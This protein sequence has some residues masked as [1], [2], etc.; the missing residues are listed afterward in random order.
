M[1][2]SSMAQELS[3]KI[4]YHDLIRKIKVAHQPIPF[5]SELSSSIRARFMI[6]DQHLVGLRYTDPEGDLI[7]V[8]S[9]VELDEL[10]GEIEASAS[11]TQKDGVHC[12][13]VVVD[14]VILKLASAPAPL[15]LRDFH[16]TGS[17]SPPF[18]QDNLNTRSSGRHSILS[19]KSPVNVP[20]S[21]DVALKFHAAPDPP[22]EVL[23][24]D[25][26]LPAPKTFSPFGLQ[27][28]PPM[29]SVVAQALAPQLQH[30][31]GGCVQQVSD[32]ASQLNNTCRL[33]A[34]CLQK[35]S[36]EPSHQSNPH[37][38]A[39]VKTPQHISSPIHTTP[40]VDQSVN[41]VISPN[42]AFDHDAPHR[43]PPPAHLVDLTEPQ[44]PEAIRPQFMMPPA[45]SGPSSQFGARLRPQ[46][47]FNDHLFTPAAAPVPELGA[48]KTLLPNNHD[49]F[50]SPCLSPAPS[51]VP[52]GLGRTACS[53]FQSSYHSPP[54]S[55]GTGN[56]YGWASSPIAYKAVKETA[57]KPT[58]G[59]SKSCRSQLKG[60]WCIWPP[61]GYGSI[62]DPHPLY[63][64]ASRA[65]PITP[66]I[67]GSEKAPS[68]VESEGFPAS[69]PTSGKEPC[70]AKYSWWNDTPDKNELPDKLN[71]HELK[72]D[73]RGF[74]GSRRQHR[75]RNHCHQRK[76]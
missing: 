60:D 56:R 18:I 69:K 7:T 11:F 55:E 19:Q 70:K 51:V 41:P 59:S 14:L 3:I 6:G 52:G 29:V 48:S 61:A 15:P 8:S 64:S 20:A 10:W 65:S 75:H 71:N 42:M 9:Q 68:L 28:F 47:L 30:T 35:V 58:F 40:L 63:S 17:S 34:D 5:W 76:G 37:S 24:E 16:S 67:A 57:P 66:S 4:K 72:W 13:V 12:K 45:S 73:S 43:A 38:S 62:V 26:P 44:K 53:S 36:I 49:G 23:V 33:V 1:S 50:V 46:N 22:E 2:K 32:V 31:L 54:I 74:H 25:A 27:A 39:F 21:P